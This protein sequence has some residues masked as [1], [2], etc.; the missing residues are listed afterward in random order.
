M[1]LNFAKE[2]AERTFTMSS[3]LDSMCLAGGCV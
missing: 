1:L 3:F 2:D